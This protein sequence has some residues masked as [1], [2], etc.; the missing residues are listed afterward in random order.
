MSANKN[1]TYVYDMNFIYKYKNLWHCFG[2]IKL[3]PVI[4]VWV[5][6]ALRPEFYVNESS[7]F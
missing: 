2:W 1:W 5:K 4:Q 3:I 6:E 7:D